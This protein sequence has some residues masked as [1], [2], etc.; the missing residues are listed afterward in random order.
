[1]KW[2]IKNLYKKGSR[3]L[4][5]TLLKSHRDDAMDADT[6]HEFERALTDEGLPED[7]ELLDD[8]EEAGTSTDAPPHSFEPPRHSMPV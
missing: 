7:V 4:A 8:N 5:K 6:L 3:S 1:V 2:V